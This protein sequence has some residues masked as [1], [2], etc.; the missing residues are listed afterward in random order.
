MQVGI[1]HEVFQFALLVIGVYGD[2]HRPDFR[3]GIE[4]GQPVGHI[5]RPDAD[6][7]PVRDADRQHSLRH[8]VRPAVELAPR[9]AE[10]AVGINEKLL[11]GRNR[12]PMLQPLSERPFL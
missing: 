12:R 3:T 7:R 2:H 4:E 5:G 1:L 6:V 9:E 10:V 8:I 11:V